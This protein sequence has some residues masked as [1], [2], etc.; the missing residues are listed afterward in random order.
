[1]PCEPPPGPCW[2]PCSLSSG[3][4]RP[5]DQGDVGVGDDRLLRQRLDL[6]LVTTV[7][8]TSTCTGSY[9]VR[10]DIYGSTSATQSSPVKAAKAC[11]SL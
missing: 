5:R 4:P 2:R 9:N 6:E 1:M 7:K 8:F 3:T 11:T 10:Y